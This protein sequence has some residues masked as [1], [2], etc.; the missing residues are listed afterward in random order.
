MGALLEESHRSLVSLRVGFILFYELFQLLSQQATN[1]GFAAGGQNA[2]FLQST[3]GETDRD[4]LF[5]RVLVRHE[6]DS[7]TC[8]ACCT[9]YTSAL[10]A[11]LQT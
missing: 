6:G 9:Y 4:V 2:R 7:I 11:K 10:S 3:S 8:N 1:R 5:C